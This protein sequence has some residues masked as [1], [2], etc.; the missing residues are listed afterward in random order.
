M[1]MKDKVVVITGSSRGI[2]KELALGFAMEGARIV[3]NYVKSKNQA[4]EVV[5]TIKDMG[6]SAISVQADVAKRRDVEKLIEETIKNFGMI[7]VLIHNAAVVEGELMLDTTDE[8]W[9]R[10]FAVNIDGCFY[11]TQISA[12]KM[13]KQGEGGRII[14]ISSICGHI[15]LYKRAAYSATKGAIQAFTQCSALELAPYGITVNAVS[16]GATNTEINIPLYTPAIREALSRR[17]P[18]GRIAEPSDMLGA[19]LFFASEE[20]SYITGQTLLVDGGWGI[21]DYTPSGEI[22]EIMKLKGKYKNGTMENPG[23]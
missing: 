8:E 13:I 10:Q 16:P 17:I 12:R 21:A 18:L 4:E 20:A 5:E 23:A 1:R 22:E 6:S 11:C 14:N 2:G 7:N 9:R 3:V 15:A 19:V